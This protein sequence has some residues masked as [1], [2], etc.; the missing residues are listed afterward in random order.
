MLDTGTSQFGFETSKP[1]GLR[2]V[3]NAQTVPRG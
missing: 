2:T 3:P 1:S